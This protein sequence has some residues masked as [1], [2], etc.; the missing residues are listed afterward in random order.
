MYFLLFVYGIVVPC[1]VAISVMACPLPAFIG[2][3]LRKLVEGILLKPFKIG[4]LTV[5]AATIM[6]VFA[7]ITFLGM[8]SIYSLLRRS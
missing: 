7:M 3:P 4:V 2:T 1:V 8:P 5:N 6:F